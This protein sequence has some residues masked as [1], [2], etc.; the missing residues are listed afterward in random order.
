MKNEEYKDTSEISI[1][2][3][4]SH[5]VLSECFVN[6]THSMANEMF[7]LDWENSARGRK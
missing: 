5:F 4:A 3:S 7:I 1:F 6:R 2:S